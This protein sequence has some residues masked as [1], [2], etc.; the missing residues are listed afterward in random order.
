MKKIFFLVSF[1]AVIFASSTL[2][3]MV[4]TK[5][6]WEQEA[7]NIPLEN[8]KLENFEE[9]KSTKKFYYPEAKYVFE[10]YNA[11]PGQREFNIEAHVF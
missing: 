6:D 9:P 1:I 4:E 8:R 10:K 2:A 5:Q 11:N 3:K 7:K